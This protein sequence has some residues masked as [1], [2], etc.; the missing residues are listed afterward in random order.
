MLCLT[1]CRPDFWET[2]EKDAHWHRWLDQAHPVQGLCRPER[3]THCK[4]ENYHHV[5]TQS[6]MVLFILIMF[7]FLPTFHTFLLKEEV[8]SMESCIKQNS[9]QQPYLNPTSCYSRLLPLAPPFLA[10]WKTN[11]IH[12]GHMEKPQCS[13]D[14]TDFLIQLQ[15]L[16]F[17]V[18]HRH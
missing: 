5:R 17:F 13:T 16:H 15:S 2:L 1:C 6:D 4:K 14:R 3:C 12:K 10:H 9:V 18:F 11:K 7:F 8:Y